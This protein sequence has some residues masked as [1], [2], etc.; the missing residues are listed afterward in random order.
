MLAEVCCRGTPPQSSHSI[1]STPLPPSTTT[2]SSVFSS[3][4]LETV[5]LTSTVTYDIS[6]HE[7]P[8]RPLESPCHS[9]SI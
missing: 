6:M 2:Q 5:S 7:S 3:T 4:D 8:Q 9:V 1:E